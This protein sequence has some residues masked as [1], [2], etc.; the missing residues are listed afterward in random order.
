MQC[1]GTYGNF[2]MAKGREDSIFTMSMATHGIIGSVTS[3]QLK[4]G[5]IFQIMVKKGTKIIRLGQKRLRKKVLKPLKRGIKA[6]KVWL[7]IANTRLKITSENSNSDIASA[8]F[9]DILLRDRVQLTN[10]VTQTARL[11]TLEQGESWKE[12]VF[13]LTVEGQHEYYVNGILVHNCMDA[14]RYAAISFKKPK[15]V[16]HTSF[17]R[18]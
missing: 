13:D 2:T 8:Q 15:P 5:N 6:L 18:L 1:T 11:K 14:F 10:F 16:F 12:E 4:E 9:V 7:G 3:P 17:G